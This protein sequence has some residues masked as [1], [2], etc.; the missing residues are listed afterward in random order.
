M[1]KMELEERLIDFAVLSSKL[2]TNYLIP[3]PATTWGAAYPFGYFAG[4]KL[5][6]SP[7]R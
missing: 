6:G 4:I 7:K 1:N 5:R 2:L 3:R